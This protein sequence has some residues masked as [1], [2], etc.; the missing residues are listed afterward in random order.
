[1][2]PDK[3]NPTQSEAMTMVCV[4]VMGNDAAVGMAASQGNFEHNGFKPVLIFNLLNS[5][6][7]LAD[8]CESF[9]DHCAVGIEPNRARIHE[10]LRRSLML[11]TALNP[12]LG[13]DRAAKIAKTAHERGQSLRETA[14]E[15]GY[16][17]GE[18]FDRVV[19][20]STMIG[21]H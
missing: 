1:I 16:L 7:L 12:V 14:V 20:P 18:E 11:V 4:Q 19:D 9:N 13:Y 17:S 5:V 3:V 21:P 8:A 10:N 2:M 6:R 15:L